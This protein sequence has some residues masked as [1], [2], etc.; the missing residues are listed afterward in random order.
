MTR[1]VTLGDESGT[2]DLNRRGVGEFKNGRGLFYDQET[3]NGRS[4]WVRFSMIPLSP[5]SARSEQAFSDDGG[6]TWETNWINRY[7][8]LMHS[9]TP[10]R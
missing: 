1:Q 7:T 5:T 3:Y 8:R 2:P 10:Y 6:K 4:I 9:E